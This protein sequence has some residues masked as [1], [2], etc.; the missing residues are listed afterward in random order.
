MVH[1]NQNRLVTVIADII[2]QRL[3]SRVHES[4][5]NSLFAQ[6]RVNL[7]CRHRFHIKTPLCYSP[8]VTNNSRDKGRRGSSSSH[9]LVLR[10][11]SDFSGFS[12]LFPSSYPPCRSPRS[13][14]SALYPRLATVRVLTRYS[15][16]KCPGYLILR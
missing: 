14:L 6:L 7:W 15:I 9:L 10:S 8:M 2:W 1:G 13:N 12:S 11:V 5:D 4:G 16:I 3:V